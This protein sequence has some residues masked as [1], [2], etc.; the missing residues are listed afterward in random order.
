MPR[1]NLRD[2]LEAAAARLRETDAAP[3]AGAIDTVLA[4]GGWAALRDSAPSTVDGSLM[5]LRLGAE[6]RNKVVD[7][8]SE[9]GTTVGADVNEA[10]RAFLAGKFVPNERA[11]STHG[12]AKNV[13]LS[14][15]PDAS[16]RQRVKERA[17]VNPQA[18]AVDY[19]LRK[20]SLGPYAPGA[21]TPLTRGNQRMPYVPRHLRDAIREAAGST[22]ATDDVNEGY[23]QYLAGKFTPV[24][25]TWPES[26]DLV[27][28]KLWPDNELHNQVAAKAKAS[29]LRPMQVAIAYLLHKY[30]IDPSAE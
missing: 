7:A 25:P 20:Y 28:L 1:I 29:K 30:G 21:E 14:V 26:D 12:R 9:A 4:P 10:F 3:L 19:L 5:Q 27:P 2:Q 6:L 16:L 23:Q 17:K 22:P 8:A 18:V 13:I 11:S 15:S 24:A